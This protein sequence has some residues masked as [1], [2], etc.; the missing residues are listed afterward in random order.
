MKKILIVALL[1]LGTYSCKA[2]QIIAVED[3]NDYQK[4]LPDGAYIKDVNNVL[5]K[6]VGVWKGV[7]NSI[8]YEFRIKKYTE[9]NTSLKYKEDT[10]I[11]RYKIVDS[12]GNVIE[13]TTGLSDSNKL[14]VKGSY[15]AKSGGYVLYYQGRESDCGQKGNIYI[16]AYGSN[17]SKLQ[18]FLIVE[19][20]TLGDNC[21]NG[22][23]KQIIPIDDNITFVKQ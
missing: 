6:Y 2:Q 11:M 10:L 5:G 15:V 20:D 19:N 14:V 12:S 22:D 3:F 1:M 7:H 16:S 4:E 13:D 8:S 17:L 23:T 9:N 21:G 18:L